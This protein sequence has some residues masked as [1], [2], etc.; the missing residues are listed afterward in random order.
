MGNSIKYNNYWIIYIFLF[1]LF[2]FDFSFSQKIKKKKKLKTASK[3]QYFSYWNP[4]RRLLDGKDNRDFFISKE[5]YE[6]KKNKNGKIKFVTK[7]DT[8]GNK[9]DTW[10][11]L[12][13]RKGERSEY[14]IYF[15]QNGRITRLDSLLFS[16]KLSEVKKGWTA[17]VKSRKDGRP[18]R[19]DIYD[20]SGI[21]YYFYR[22]HYNKRSDKL[23]SM[24]TIQCS[25]FRDDSTLVG[26]HILFMEN[27][28]WLREIHFKNADNKK[29]KIIKYDVNLEKE[30]TVK[31]VLDGDGREVE[32]RIIQLSYPDKFS[33]RFEWKPDT[34]MIVENITIEKD[35][36]Y[37]YI[38]PVFLSYWSGFPLV[39]GS[40]LSNEEIFPYSGFFFAPRGN[41]SFRGNEYSLG[42]ELISYK[43]PISL[44]DEYIDGIGLFAAVQYNLNHTFK[45]IPDNI[46][47]A[48]RLGGGMLQFGNG[49]SF[50]TSFGY[51]F[52]PTRYYMGI[53][54][55]SILAFDE[56][57]NGKTT[58][59]AGLGFSLGANLGELNPELIKSY[60]DFWEDDLL[61]FSYLKKLFTKSELIYI[62]D[63]PIILEDNLDDFYRSNSGLNGLKIRTPFSAKIGIIDF[64]LLM[65]YLE[66]FFDSKTG[67]DPNFKGQAILLGID[68]NFNNLIKFGGKQ[69]SKSLVL[70]FGSFHSGLGLTTGFDIDYY[71]S[72]I[73][74]NINTYGKYYGFSNDQVF[75]GWF[76]LGIGIGIDF[77]KLSSKEKN[78]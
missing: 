77:E 3:P 32:S 17:K 70:E 20:A 39:Y 55:N 40:A 68:I 19:F 45:W 47:A 44:S 37:E 76:S 23:L 56:V 38:S 6:S 52:L 74:I 41:M 62:K 30:E 25:Y 10:N 27:G 26:R 78:K 5:F 60:K 42:L 29:E 31:T 22:F 73:P 58:G 71:F 7:Y 54:A 36:S 53:Y 51:H 61:F 21:R 18:L 15:H 33:Y 35:T 34:I 4:Y 1:S 63:K 75:T 69:I 12:W 72:K 57:E 9:V 11:L 14:S 59:W 64:N 8:N 46:E 48:L 28:E 49:L 24:E 2:F 67:R 16:H 65:S 13:D 43:I 66:Y 50:S